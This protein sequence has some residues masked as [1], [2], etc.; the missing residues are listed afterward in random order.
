[1]YNQNYGDRSIVDKMM[2]MFII[3]AISG[4]VTRDFDTGIHYLNEVKTHYAQNMSDLNPTLKGLAKEIIQSLDMFTPGH[5]ASQFY[6]KNDSKDSKRE[7]QPRSVTEEYSNIVKKKDKK[8]DKKEQMIDEETNK[9]K[10]EKDELFGDLGDLTFEDED[11][12]ETNRKLKDELSGKKSPI[13]TFSDEDN[14][15]LEVLLKRKSKKG[16]LSK[17]DQQKLEVLEEKKQKQ[18]EREQADN[19]IYNIKQK[20][21]KRNRDSDIWND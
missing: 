10:K 11:I 17:G 15:I 9:A 3:Q 12:D 13:K 21:T 20:R 18:I 1:L 4:F 6:S 7:N 5:D 8:K 19:P 16:K 14:A 2:R